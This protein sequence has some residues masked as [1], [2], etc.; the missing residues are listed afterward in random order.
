MGLVM[1]AIAMW[2]TGAGAEQPGECVKVT[3]AGA[4][5]ADAEKI[6]CGSSEAVYEV[7]VNRS[8]SFDTCPT[9]DYSKYTSRGRRSNGY[10]LCP[11]LNASVGDCF[12]DEGSFTSGKTTKVPCD[13][14]A[15][16][17]VA[18]VL[19][20]NDESACKNDGESAIT[21]SEPGTTL[22]ITKP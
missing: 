17:K 9:G 22:C 4:G 12:K 15:S 19:N 7:A 5:S 14:S 3:G 10:K 11:M 21:Y 1:S 18:Q 8:S 6:D 13:S 20:R 2:G 16:F